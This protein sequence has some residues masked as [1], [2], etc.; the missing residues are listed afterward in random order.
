M[1]IMSMAAVFSQ[2]GSIEGR[3]FGYCSGYA[4]PEV[5]IR[6][7]Q[8]PN[9]CAEFACW[10]PMLAGGGRRDWPGADALGHINA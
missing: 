7:E 4:V 6:D 10:P 8:L 1:L 9:S 5:V 2:S 3:L